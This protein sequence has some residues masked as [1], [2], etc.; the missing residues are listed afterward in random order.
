MSSTFHTVSL[1]KN[2]IFHIPQLINS[3]EIEIPPNFLNLLLDSEFYF[4]FNPVPDIIESDTI[5]DPFIGLSGL[6]RKIL[7]FFFD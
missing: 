4:D 3:K 1:A 6:I 2:F 5:V 7:F